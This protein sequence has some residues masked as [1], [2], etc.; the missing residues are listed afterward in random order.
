MNESGGATA[1]K[2]Q[3]NT[4]TI[5]IKYENISHYIVNIVWKQP[6]PHAHDVIYFDLYLSQMCEW[7]RRSV[8]ELR[9]DEQRRSWSSVCMLSLTIIVF[10]QTH[11]PEE[12]K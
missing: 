2:Y 4:N 6:S 9:M 1:N 7:Q 11:Q 12:S 3:T 10:G 8:Q 5:T